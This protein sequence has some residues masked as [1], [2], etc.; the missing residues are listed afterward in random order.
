MTTRIEAAMVL[1]AATTNIPLGYRLNLATFLPSMAMVPIPK[2]SGLR[3][4]LRCSVSTEKVT[5]QNRNKVGIM[6][7]SFVEHPIVWDSDLRTQAQNHRGATTSPNAATSLPSQLRKNSLACHCATL[8][9]QSVDHILVPVWAFPSK[10]RNTVAEQKR[11]KRHLYAFRGPSLK[12]LAFPHARQYDDR[13]VAQK[14]SL[15]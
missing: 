15:N 2:S 5:Q 10:P 7:A 12:I 13:I 14:R 3:L 1:S 11:E 4:P 8:D 9:T 6:E